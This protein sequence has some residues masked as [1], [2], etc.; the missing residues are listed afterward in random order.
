MIDNLPAQLTHFVGREQEAA[1]IQQ[2]LTEVRLL[3]L[4][5]PGGGGKTRL[6]IEVAA[7]LADAYPDGIFW[8][9]LAPSIPTPPRRISCSSQVF[10]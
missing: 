1:D 2:L 9:E 4:T 3:T 5:G 8:V 6:A 7:T 10:R